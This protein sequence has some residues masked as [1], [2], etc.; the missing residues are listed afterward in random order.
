MS[1][2]F[3]GPLL[4]Q[5][6]LAVKGLHE[7]SNIHTGTPLHE[8]TECTSDVVIAT[9]HVQLAGSCV[10]RVPDK[11]PQKHPGLGHQPSGQFLPWYNMLRMIPLE[12]PDFFL[13]LDNLSTS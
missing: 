7:F 11:S 2:K 8:H 9:S 12:L 10:T 3:K 6:S 4:S 5:V 13:S 1:K